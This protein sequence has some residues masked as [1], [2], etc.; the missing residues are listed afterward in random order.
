MIYRRIHEIKNNHPMHLRTIFLCSWHYKIC[1]NPHK[2]EFFVG[3]GHFLGFL[4]S[5]EGIRIDPL[6]VQAILDLPMPSN[7]LQIQKLQGKANFLRRFIPN[8]VE[9][10]KG[11]TR[12][13]K[14][15]VPFHWDQFAQASFD[16]FKDT[17]VQAPLMYP[18]KYQN[19]Y[20]LI[21]L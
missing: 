8:Y 21:S 14:N 7:L 19:N 5:K 13:L 15:G 12:F 3:F 20:F 4:V 6:K 9:M 17:L 10:A 11:F 18:H 16:V 2:C 1:L